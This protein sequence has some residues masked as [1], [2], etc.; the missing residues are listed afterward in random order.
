MLKRFD[1]QKVPQ[2]WGFD[3]LRPTAFP[4]VISQRFGRAKNGDRTLGS[5]MPAEWGETSMT[6]SQQARH[7]RQ[8]GHVQVVCAVVAMICAVIAFIEW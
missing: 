2:A 1:E 4:P 8:L 7:D 5:E 3:W 6:G